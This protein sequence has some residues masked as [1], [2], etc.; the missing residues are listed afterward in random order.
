MNGLVAPTAEQLPCKEKAESS[1]LSKSTKHC[2]QCGLDKPSSEF[3]N[4]KSTKFKDG[5]WPY[6][7]SCSNAR[8]LSWYYANKGTARYQALAFRRRLQRYGLTVETYNALL[9]RQEG[10][11]AVCG[12][13]GELVIDHDHQCCPAEQSCGG[14]VRG[15]LCQRC[16]RV[17][18]NLAD[19]VDLVRSLLRYAES[20][21]SRLMRGERGKA[22]TAA[23]VSNRRGRPAGPIKHGTTWAYNGRGCRCDLCKDA[24]HRAR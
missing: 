12:A 22:D 9:A 4:S 14:C 23:K 5:K 20:T 19:S 11:C 2:K 1:N 18:G 3:H 8:A 24:R 6:C 17:F 21:Q 16:N 15:L 7:R 13:G 10:V